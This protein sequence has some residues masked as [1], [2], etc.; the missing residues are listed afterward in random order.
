MLK[1]QST[2][3]DL[4]LGEEVGNNTASNE[5]SEGLTSSRGGVFVKSNV[6]FG[7]RLSDDSQV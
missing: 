6:N 3:A 5:M 7:K 2:L 4:A 1:E